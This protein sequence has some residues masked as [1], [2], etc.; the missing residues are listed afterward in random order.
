[1]LISLSSPV[2]AFVLA[3]VI[4]GTVP[5]SYELAGGVVMLV[6]IALPVIAGLRR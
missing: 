4:L 1:V 6:G 5:T 3:F 2:F